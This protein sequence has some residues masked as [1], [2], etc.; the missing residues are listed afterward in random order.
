MNVQNQIDCL[1]NE[2]KTTLQESVHTRDFL[3]KILSCTNFDYIYLAFL[4]KNETNLSAEIA[5]GLD[6]DKIPT[7]IPNEPSLTRD[8]FKRKKYIIYPTLSKADN[9]FISYKNSPK[10]QTELVVPVI[11]Q[12]VNE[13][14]L[15]LGNFKPT[16]INKTVADCI[17]TLTDLF[18]VTYFNQ[19]FNNYTAQITDLRFSGNNLGM[20]T[21]KIAK[22]CSNILG[23]EAVKVWIVDDTKQT[24]K[25]LFLA[26][27][28]G[29]LLENI[30]KYYILE[31]E[32]SMSWQYINRTSA[33]LE[34]NSE[35]MQTFYAEDIFKSDLLF[36]YKS[37]A[38]NNQFRSVLSCPLIFRSS[39]LGL[40]NIY[41]KRKSKFSKL[42]KNLFEGIARYGSYEIKECIE[43]KFI[44][45]I[46]QIC[47]AGTIAIDYLHDLNH[48]LFDLSSLMSNYFA[49]KKGISIADKNTKNQIKYKFE[50]LNNLI[51]TLQNISKEEKPFFESYNL[52]RLLKKVE[53]FMD[54][55]LNGITLKINCD[56]NIMVYCDRLKI[57]QVFM[58]LFHNSIYALGIS[59]NKK[60]I[61]IIH[62]SKPS[63]SP[64]DILITFFD[65][66]P[67][68][69]PIH[70]DKVFKEKFTTR[71]NS[72]TGV[73]LLLCRKSIVEV[74]K[75]EILFKSKSNQEGSF[76]SILLYLYET[77]EKFENAD[78]RGY[79]VIPQS[80]SSG[81]TV[82]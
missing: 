11:F 7:I 70:I 54:R 75:G 42:E 51:S 9:Y 79:H 43:D 1:L 25:K 4:N 73:G 24:E 65:N 6:I 77:K 22:E 41:T 12:N 46:T 38:K 34:D 31:S 58:N 17:Q 68:I 80:A 5:L 19:K 71:T 49:N 21:N 78:K 59:K 16:V 33:A 56:P 32:S 18:A 81:Y 76:T 61:I 50:Y 3:G 35:Y 40:I 28:S 57:T 53:Y 20:V 63:N 55:K 26:G 8:V 23:V 30:D 62:V 69:N 14:V 27:H 45:H 36:K 44:T 10:V 72:G 13:G 47:N 67:G 2:V 37:E 52:L 48:L 60:K 66:G 39:I 74:H 29:P 64:Y 82:D 15:V